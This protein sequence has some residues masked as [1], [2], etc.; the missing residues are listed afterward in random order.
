MSFDWRMYLTNLFK[1][2]AIFAYKK[3]LLENM[4]DV[5]I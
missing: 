1:K 3:V 2:L 4:R 5:F